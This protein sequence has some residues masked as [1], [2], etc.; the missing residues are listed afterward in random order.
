MNQYAGSAACLQLQPRP[1]QRAEVPLL[2]EATQATGTEGVAARC[3]ERLNKRLQADVAHKVI[4]Y[5]Q[6][7]VVEVV[8][9]AAVDLATLRT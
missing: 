5:F 8:L 3:V 1:I 6:A 9:P 2:E 4:V 7:V